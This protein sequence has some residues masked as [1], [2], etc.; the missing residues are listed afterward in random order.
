MTTNGTAIKTIAR[1]QPISPSSIP[2][3][4]PG[5]IPSCCANGTGVG[6][7]PGSC[8]NAAGVTL[9]GAWVGLPVAAA[10]ACGAAPMGTKVGTWVGVNTGVGFEVPTRGAALMDARQASS[11]PFVSKPYDD[12]NA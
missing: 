11:N 1:T 5:L 3:I 2:V 6:A 7:G 8:V 9:V 4:T 10:G 12:C